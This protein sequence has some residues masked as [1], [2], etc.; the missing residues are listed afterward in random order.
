MS[1]HREQHQLRVGRPQVAPDTPSHT[2]GIREGNQPGNYERQSGHGRDGRSTAARST[3]VNASD[4]DPI[5]PDMPNL[6]P[7]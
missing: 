4:R 7:A 6:S 5:Q 3:G 2:K 1:H